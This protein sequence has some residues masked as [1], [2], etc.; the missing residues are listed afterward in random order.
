M[1]RVKRITAMA[2]TIT[3][4][5]ALIASSLAPL[6]VQASGAKAASE[7]LEYDVLEPEDLEADA[8]E[9]EA[10]EPEDLEAEV[11]ESEILES[12]DLDSEEL[13][14]EVAE[15]TDD[16][17]YS[18]SGSPN[19]TSVFVTGETSFSFTPNVTGYWT[20]EATHIY[21][22]HPHFRVF[23]HYGHQLASRSDIITLHLVEGVPYVVDVSCWMRGDFADGNGSFT[24]VVS[25]S[26]EFIPPT[27]PRLEPN[28]IPGSGGHSEGYDDIYYIFTPDT[29]GLW[30]ILIDV[31]DA[32]LVYFSITDWDSNEIAFVYD[33]IP[34][35][36]GTVRLVSGVEYRLR[37]WVEWDHAYSIY[38]SPAEEFI[39]WFDWEWLF[40][41]MDEVGL[42]V[43][44]ESDE[45]IIP[46]S[47]GS[48]EVDGA[49]S[50]TFTPEETGPW[51][52]TADGGSADMI[53]ILTDSYG[54][55]ITLDEVWWGWGMH[56]IKELS[57]GV[58]YVI[59]FAPF[60]YSTGSVTFT[61]TSYEGIE[62]PEDDD[63][64]DWEWQWQ[65][66]RI[67]SGGGF[68]VVDLDTMYLF[69]PEF[70]GSWTID[71]TYMPWGG[72]SIRDES[73][74]FRISARE[75]PSISVHL[76]AG[77][78]YVIDTGEAGWRQIAILNISPT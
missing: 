67:P 73:S 30:E 74:S 28:E 59:R 7:T 12:E 46:P 10:L 19:T 54:S 39:P 34:G 25:V 15:V 9:S 41:L 6:S 57:Q 55:F 1:K 61:V 16:E 11:L 78:E 23:N 5:A 64:W 2:I 29:C 75:V 42:T 36:H 45:T 4:V 49:R 40:E 43:D 60:A 13:E 37:G 66:E 35:F 18:P 70:T 44:L 47:G 27:S 77:N 50:F 31:D 22:M 20:F 14:A 8:L 65:E 62:W 71:L 52:F 76:A 38:I 33:P 32:E 56:F 48:F 68:T 24:L 17:T 51:F 69:S 26:D 3:M 53:V 58:E 21:D 72:I 63:T